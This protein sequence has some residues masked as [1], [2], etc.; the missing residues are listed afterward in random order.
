MRFAGLPEFDMTEAG[1]RKRR[2]FLNALYALLGIG[3]LAVLIVAV[4][5]KRMV[6]IL[7]GA[8]PIYLGLMVVLALSQFV[9][10]SIVWRRLLRRRN[11]RVPLSS[12]VG[13]YL[14]G[15]FVSTILPTKYTGDIYR[16]F[17]VSRRTGF[18][19][20]VAASVLLER[21]SGIFVLVLMGLGAS[22]FAADLL[23]EGA[24]PYAIVGVLLALS[25]GTWLLFSN[26]LYGIASGLFSRLRLRFLQRPMKRFRL[27]VMKYRGEGRFLLR[28]N[29]LSFAFKSVA[30]V[31]I[32]LA[33]LSIGVNVPFISVILIMPL[34]YVLEA[35]PI[36]IQG[37]GVREGAFVLFF[38]RLGLSYEEAFALSMVVLFGRVVCAIVGGAVFLAGRVGERGASV[39]SPRETADARGGS[40]DAFAQEGAVR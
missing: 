4:D 18:P 5:M 19:Y 14:A 24:V 13:A 36:S 25:T 34:I 37:L 33:A 6:S 20:D 31:C 28:T 30:F 22:F 12:L 3:I 26:R 15:N 1:G 17:A 9:L 8:N 35:L 39:S 40:R 38:S 10:A 16:T 29:L 32:F 2:R 27:A 23:G 21:L 11:L 7:K